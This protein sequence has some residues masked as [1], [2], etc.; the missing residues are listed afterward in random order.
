MNRLCPIDEYEDFY[1]IPVKLVHFNSSANGG[2]PV[3]HLKV[4]F[5]ME[6]PRSSRAS[7]PTTNVFNES[8]KVS[9][10]KRMQISCIYLTLE[11]EILAVSLMCTS[12]R[13]D[14]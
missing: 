11:P 4:G 1:N 3:F 10:L 13:T 14:A 7:I 5:Q 6:T 9:V 2:E 8:M 12:M